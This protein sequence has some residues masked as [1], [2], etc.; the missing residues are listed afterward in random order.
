MAPPKCTDGT[1]NS[2]KDEKQWMDIFQ[3][4]THLKIRHQGYAEGG[5]ASEDKQ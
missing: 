5:E 3:N 4:D 1:F 2:W